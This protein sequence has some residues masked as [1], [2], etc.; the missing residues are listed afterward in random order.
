VRLSQGQ[1][2]AAR[3][4]HDGREPDLGVLASKVYS[5][6]ARSAR[7]DQAQNHG[8]GVAAA[9]GGRLAR[10]LCDAAGLTH[11]SGQAR[12]PLAGKPVRGHPRAGRDAQ[13]AGVAGKR[14][15]PAAAVAEAEQQWR[16]YAVGPGHRRRNGQPCEP[17]TPA[18][19]LHFGPRHQLAA[20]APR[21]RVLGVHVDAWHTAAAWLWRLYR[22]SQCVAVANKPHL[23]HEP[24]WNRAAPL[25]VQPNDDSLGP[26]P[27]ATAARPDPEPPAPAPAPAPSAP[28]ARVC[29]ARFGAAVSAHGAGWRRQP[30]C[31]WPQ[32]S[33]A[34]GDGSELGADPGRHSWVTVLL[35][36]LGK[37]PVQ[38]QPQLKR[39]EGHVQ[40]L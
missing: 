39:H 17:G 40:S 36:W 14:F 31:L 20:A 19:D 12:A 22:R 7:A 28:S 6:Q 35:C 3:P 25:K 9:R 34:A 1:Q 32:Y 38:H 15:A 4:P 18:L 2:V 27:A 26:Q 30:E 23:Q 16:V 8:V 13:E 37:Q 33:F 10:K 21:A 11:R 29:V 24:A 5:R